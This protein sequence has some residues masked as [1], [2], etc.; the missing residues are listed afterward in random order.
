L[1]DSPPPNAVEFLLSRIRSL[2]RDD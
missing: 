1:F 2:A